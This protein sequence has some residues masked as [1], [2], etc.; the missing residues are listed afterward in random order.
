VCRKTPR[1]VSAHRKNILSTSKQVN[2]SQQHRLSS[3][4]PLTKTKQ[5]LIKDGSQ[6]RSII[7]GFATPLSSSTTTHTRYL[8]R[9]LLHEQPTVI[10]L[11][12]RVIQVVD[13]SEE[14][15]ICPAEESSRR[16]HHLPKRS[17]T[18]SSPFGQPK[19]SHQYQVTE[20]IIKSYYHET[21]F[22]NAL[23]VFRYQ[24]F[25]HSTSYTKSILK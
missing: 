18:S 6:R 25:K 21:Y 11:R 16:I 15:T 13:V 4:P 14:S 19:F 1:R 3:L 10:I 23:Q 9:N 24:V 20:R 12:A 5:R 17:S 22:V 7:C 8:V 2:T